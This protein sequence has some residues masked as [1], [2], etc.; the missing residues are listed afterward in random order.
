MNLK[1]H[2]NRRSRKKVL[3][4][5]NTHQI[6]LKRYERLIKMVFM[7]WY[8]DIIMNDSHIFLNFTIMCTCFKSRRWREKM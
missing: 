7:V 8:H 5:D 3:K 2:Y 4:F 1:I 6:K